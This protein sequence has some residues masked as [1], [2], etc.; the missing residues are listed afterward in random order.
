MDP[1]AAKLHR[2]PAP[3][4][5]AVRQANTVTPVPQLA[6]ALHPAASPADSDRP[7]D[8]APPADAE[9]REITVIEPRSARGMFTGLDRKY[10]AELLRHRELL[11]FLVWRDVK[12]K[13][14]M[15]ALGIAW[16]AVVPLVSTLIYGGAGAILNFGGGEGTPW[17]LVIA[18]GMVPW[19]FIQKCVNDGGQ[20]L[21]NHQQL[22]SKI[23]LPR[24]FIPTS[25]V[26]VALVDLVVALVVFVGFALLYAVAGRWVPSVNLLALPL[27]LALT[28]V[29]G[30]GT[31][32][33]LSGLTVLYRDVRFLI[34]FFTQF[35][36]WLSAV[37]WPLQ[38]LGERAWML[39]WNPYAGIVSAWR[40][41]LIG[42]P[43]YP[44]LIL[45]SVIISPLLLVFGMAYFRRVER[46]F[47]DIA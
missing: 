16:A 14:K 15:A 29:A 42:A 35:G 18:A 31:S 46:R 41:V 24:V 21:I 38:D 47:A 40:S 33:G 30:A 20:S 10:V 11:G 27:V 23:Y 25:S 22:L 19:I 39:S 44:S 36:L 4:R 37:V 26:G 3:R 6:D 12:V 5:G 28:I 7:V 43:W 17:F 2:V 9:P 1:A 13:Y 32:I 45:G 8:A 34:P